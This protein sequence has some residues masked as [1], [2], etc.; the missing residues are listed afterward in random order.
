MSVA[1]SQLEVASPDVAPSMTPGVQRQAFYLISQGQPLFAWLHFSPDA[2]M[3]DHGVVICPPV[4]HEQLHAHRTL[5]HLA[6][7]LARQGVATLRFDWH[8]TGDSAG[9]DED[10]ARGSTWLTNLR[11]AIDWMRQELGCRQV[12]TVGLRIGALLSAL[13]SE[14]NEIA[15]LVLWAPVTNGRAY[16]REMTALD[17][18]AEFRPQTQ[19][20]AAGDIEAAGF[21]LSKLAAA[22]L[23]QWNLLKSHPWCQRALVVA[24]D[25][26]PADY[27]LRER[28]SSL[29][30]QVDQISVPGYLEML[31][32]PHRSHVPTIAIQN[33]VNWLLR[34]IKTSVPGALNPQLLPRATEVL[35]RP[36]AEGSEPFEQ[37]PQIRER[38]L[39]ISDSPHVFG[40]LSEPERPVDADLPTIVLLNAG[41]AYRIGPGRMT[42][43]IARQLAARGYRCLRLDVCG[44]G[45]SVVG[46]NGVENDAYS[47]AA[48]RSVE[49]ALQTLRADFGA[50]QCVVTGLCSGAYLAFQS[51]ASLDDPAFVESVLINPLTF[52]WKDG[53]TIESAPVAH[54]VAQHHYWSSA[55]RPGKWVKLLAG[56][57]EIGLVGSLKLLASRCGLGRQQAAAVMASQQVHENRGSRAGG[58]PVEDD[59]PGD[60]ARIVANGRSLAMIFAATDP[61]YSILMHKAHRQAKKFHR[62]GQLQFTFIKDADHTF[63]RRS[64]RQALVDALYVHLRQRFQGG[65]IGDGC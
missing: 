3:V 22:E 62:S 24:R 13:A 52:F 59:L 49:L 27:R 34:R 32:E 14:E 19:H 48:F 37:L 58:H 60:L 10:P 11:D 42:V 15:N 45:D 55:L 6:D 25:D 17:L 21:V 41:A 30:V 33:I 63:S 39:N 40:I 9:I 46:A 36:R 28:C 43:H 29:G 61:G 54:L 51:A 56:R 31:A 18:T 8:G 44:L 20:A 2:P 7:D 26:V 16:V 1:V 57:T 53:M 38:A 12:S 23:S 4:G 47:P 35:M 64:A 65:G 50:Q 5:R